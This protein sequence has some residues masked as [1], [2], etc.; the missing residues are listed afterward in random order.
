MVCL[1]QNFQNSPIL[2]KSPTYSPRFFP[3]FG[4]FH[5]KG[6]TDL[7][8]PSERSYKELLNAC[9]TFEIRHSKLKLWAP[10][11]G[12]HFWEYNVKAKLN[13]YSLHSPCLVSCGPSWQL[14]PESA[15]TL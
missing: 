14:P 5:L 4:E 6:I 2:T 12:Y 3:N 13:E 10:K 11:V 1:V 7:S 15:S 9:F 8:T